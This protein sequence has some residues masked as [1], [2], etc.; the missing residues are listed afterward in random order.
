LLL[1]CAEIDHVPVLGELF[2]LDTHSTAKEK[3]MLDRRALPVSA[4]IAGS[5]LTTMKANAQSGAC[6][7]SMKSLRLRRLVDQDRINCP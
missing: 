1:Q 6:A 3:K 5:A 2:G 4:A 7:L